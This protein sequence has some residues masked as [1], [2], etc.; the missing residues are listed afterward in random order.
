[1][2]DLHMHLT[3]YTL[4]KTSAAFQWPHNDEGA[5]SSKRHVEWLMQYLSLRGIN[6][7]KL[8]C[9]ITDIVIK[10]IFAVQPTLSHMELRSKHGA[11]ELLGFDILIDQNLRPWLLEV[12][13]SPS[14]ACD[15]LVDRQVKSSVVR[16]ALQLVAW[17]HVSR[18]YGG[19]ATVPAPIHV[20]AAYTCVHPAAPDVCAAAG[21]RPPEY[22]TRLLCFP[23]PEELFVGG[24]LDPSQAGVLMSVLRNTST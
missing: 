20:A 18:V 9:D 21:L 5:S 13:Q 7:R 12:N 24:F 10:T 6:T 11:F 1:M 17:H 23:V 19:G 14:L 16:D 3:N 15:T 4:N 22:Y 8:W 2:Q